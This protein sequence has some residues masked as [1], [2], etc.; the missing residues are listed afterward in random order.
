[1]TPKSLL[2]HPDAKSSFDDMVEGTGFKRLIPDDGPVVDNAERVKKLLFCTGKIYYDLAKER[3]QKHRTEDV[4][5][6]RVE[7]VSSGI[8]TAR[9]T[10]P[11]TAHFFGYVP[12]LSQERG[13]LRISNFACTFMGSIGTEAH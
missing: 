10:Y 9:Y 3:E 12:L 6:T 5:I 13:K 2:R 1:M 7:Q 11:G 8:F 4:A